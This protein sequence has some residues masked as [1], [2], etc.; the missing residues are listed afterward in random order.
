MHLGLIAL[1]LRFCVSRTHHGGAAMHNN[2]GLCG[3]ETPMTGKFTRHARVGIVACVFALLQLSFSS[4]R[5]F[6]A[7]AA[8]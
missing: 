3:P 7:V 5:C 1:C 6:R 4:L 8:R 2:E